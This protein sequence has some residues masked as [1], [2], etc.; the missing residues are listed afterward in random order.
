VSEKVVYG[1]KSIYFFWL[2]SLVMLFITFITKEFL[3]SERIY[4]NSFVEQFGIDQV[5]LMIEQNAKWG[6]LGYVIVL[7]NYFIKSMLVA[8]CLSL[9]VFISM[10]KFAFKRG[11]F[12]IYAAWL[13]A[14]VTQL[15]RL[16]SLR[17]LKFS[18]A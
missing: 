5:E 6:W 8:I 4:Y 13:N 16:L 15:H 9:G 12:Q 14:C 10:D 3:I 18:I 17:T 2:V 7:V 11:A 1:L